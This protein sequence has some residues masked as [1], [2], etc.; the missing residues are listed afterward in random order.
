GTPE[1]ALRD[2]DPVPHTEIMEYALRRGCV[3]V[4]ASGNSG[5]TTRYFPAASPGVIA[6]GAVDAT[7]APARFTTRGDH[8]ALSA[9]GVAVC[10]A[11]L[12]GDIVTCS[13]TSFA[14]AFVAGAAALVL[15]AGNRRGVPLSPYTVRDLLMRSA[16]PFDALVD[17]S[18]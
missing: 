8:V 14:S 15:A 17:A 16:H 3:L 9:P 4:A 2:G 13:G 10:C 18:G 1:T 5:D 11:G 7:G 6:V 12:S